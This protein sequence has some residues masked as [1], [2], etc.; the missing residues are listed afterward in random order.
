VFPTYNL[1]THL[2]GI[3]QIK[4]MYVPIWRRV[5]GMGVGG[6]KNVLFADQQK[7]NCV[8]TFHVQ[9]EWY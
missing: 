3:S 1:Q 6:F 7:Y 5:L 9:E 8:N 2:V 4:N